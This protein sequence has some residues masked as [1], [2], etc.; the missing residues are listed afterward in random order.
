ML[1]TPGVTRTEENP[2]AGDWLD[3][4][5]LWPAGIW[6]ALLFALALAGLRLA[7]RRFLVLTLALLA[8]QTVFAML[9]IGATRYRAPWDFL[10]ALLAAP[11][12]VELVRSVRARAAR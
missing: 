9:F 11:V 6:F 4:L 1:W 8:Y 5:R 7:E 2:G 10:L 12:L 3:A